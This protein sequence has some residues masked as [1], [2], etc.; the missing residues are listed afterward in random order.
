S[1]TGRGVEL[2]SQSCARHFDFYAALAGEEKSDAL[3]SVSYGVGVSKAEA[4]RLLSAEA[5]YENRIFFDEK[6][7]TFFKQEALF[8]GAFKLN[9]KSK[10]RLNSTDLNRAWKKYAQEAPET[11][12]KLNP[13]YKSI[14]IKLSF[15]Q[16]KGLVTLEDFNLKLVQK[17]SQV[18]ET[19]EDFKNC[20]LI[21]YLD[22]IELL[23]QLPS[24][25]KLPSD[26]KRI[27]KR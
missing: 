6:T 3:T 12:L 18:V 13:T 17:L 8:F 27:I 1:A 7:E 16:S 2:E 11:F 23:Q 26:K 5:Q 15:L 21:Y 9:E 22:E 10:E 14:M 4:L 19:F 24:S 25:L 20:D